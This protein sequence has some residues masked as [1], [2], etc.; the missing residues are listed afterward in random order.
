MSVTQGDRFIN[1][2]ADSLV[3]GEITWKDYINSLS[4]EDL[5]RQ[6]QYDRGRVNKWYQE[7]KERKREYCKAWLSKNK[8]R[9]AEQHEC[10]TCG[11][12]YN[13][14]TK[15]RH[16]RTKKHQNALIPSGGT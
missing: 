3:S 6:R 2:P 4:P 16:E 13:L 9:L 15:G 10:E 14:K 5:A 12:I 11:G 7:N 8:E 1:V